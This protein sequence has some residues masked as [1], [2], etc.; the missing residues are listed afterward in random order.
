MS[1]TMQPFYCGTQYMDWQSANC[2]RCK[3]GTDWSN[4]PPAFRCDIEEALS[5]AAIRE[6]SI[7]L[8]I[9]EQEKQL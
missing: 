9:A 4:M 6:G 5:L 7:P 2:D 8:P 3:K 1:D